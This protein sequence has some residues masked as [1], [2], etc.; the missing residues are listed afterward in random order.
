M[1][2]HRKDIYHSNNSFKQIR[3]CEI[4]S[5]EKWRPWKNLLPGTVL[6][7]FLAGAFFDWAGFIG[8]PAFAFLS[9]SGLTLLCLLSLL[10]LSF[11]S[12]FLFGLLT[13]ACESAASCSWTA[14]SWGQRQER[15]GGDQWSAQSKRISLAIRKD[16]L[17]CPVIGHKVHCKMVSILQLDEMKE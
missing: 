15:G 1:N 2:R 13:G 14:F 11:L 9:S 4:V 6:L 5:F 7:A 12:F 3:Q 8:C 17:G 10:S 16:S